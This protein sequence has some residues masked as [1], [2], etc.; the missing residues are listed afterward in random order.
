M[1]LTI[2]S[3][4]IAL[5]VLI[6]FHEFGHFIV[7]KRSGI[8]VEEFS[9][10]LGPKIIGIKKGETTYRLSLIPLGGY[11]KL[12]GMDPKE[13][14][15]E[16]YE[17]T[18]KRT[19]I[20]IAV[21]LAGPVFNFVLA[22]F[23]FT[24]IN[25][26]FG[27][28]TLPT[29]TVKS[30]GVQN[31][32]PLQSGDQILAINGKEAHTWNDILELLSERD[33]SQCS[34]KRE[35]VEQEVILPKSISLELEPLIPPIIGK[36]AKDGPAY[37]AGIQEG[38]L[39][40]KITTKE[41]EGEDTL[42]SIIEIKGWDS[43]VSVIHRNPKKEV[44][45]EW[46]H[47]GNHREAKIIPDKEQVLIDDKVI[48]VGMIKVLM[49]IERKPMGIRAFKLGFLQSIDTFVI[50]LSIFKKLILR[51]I[52]TK[53]LGGP[54]AIV[55]FAG[56]SARWGLES[57]LTLMAFLSINLL[58]LNIIPFPP[59]DGGQ[60]LLI[61]IEKIRRKPISERIITLI[62]NVGFALLMVLILYITIN[63]ITRWIKK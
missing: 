57:F 17:F 63:D 41:I 37:R 28:P 29:T 1:L 45:V 22:F 23:L 25:F 61:L 3:A 53:T 52:S 46:L 48:D 30:V 54:L 44:S 26:I 50:T 7:A 55:K 36:V 62:Q 60:V 16:P 59:L 21:I 56:E 2:I 4:I 18:S 38:D 32:E 42:V 11:V 51:K 9:L 47:N 6:I 49:K 31:F 20:K 19:P 39:I 5:S 33:S 34:I 10:G 40:T 43:L 8:R 58:I 12:A 13:I 27:I 24:I 14:K 15:G 35:G